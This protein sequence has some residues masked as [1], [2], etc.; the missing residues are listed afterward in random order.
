MI[1]RRLFLVLGI[2]FLPFFYVQAISKSS[3]LLWDESLKN[4]NFQKTKID[5]DLKKQNQ[6]IP[7]SEE[8]HLAHFVHGVLSF[9]RGEMK[10][11]KT[12]LTSSLELREINPYV[13][14]YLGRIAMEQKNFKEAFQAFKRALKLKPQ[15]DLRR[16][17][18]LEL[19][20]VY[21]NQKKLKSARKIFL[22]I[23]KKFQ[24]TETYPDILWDLFNIDEKL[25]Y[26]SKCRW[27]R[28]LFENY[29]D[30]SHS[31]SWTLNP[32]TWKISKRKIRCSVR[33]SSQKKHINQL[34]AL[35]QY[36]RVID[37]IKDSQGQLKKLEYLELL[38]EYEIRAGH[39]QKAYQ[40]LKKH[41]KK[42]K[43]NK[44]FLDIF[45]K[46]ASRSLNHK[47]ALKAFNHRI[48]M[49]KRRG[50]KATLVFRKAFLQYE[51]GNYEKAYITFSKVPKIYRRITYQGDT[52]WY[53]GWTA[54]LQKKYKKALDHFGTL[55]GSFR[56]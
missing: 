47:E 36:S 12:S 53:L 38:A 23:R 29:P 54:Y 56:V 44:K 6:K 25:K 19:A 32:R 17:I 4:L 8:G 22:Q 2:L 52:L 10:E 37:E 46:V 45:I 40:E 13:Y 7:S 15:Y 26:A 50:K 51:L 30:Y 16:K 27:F 1:M 48:Q 3:I 14:Y 35:G 21:L 43:G 49:E 20:K 55:L 31:H 5:V 33:F 9:E 18:K 41:Y 28:Y 24:R 39:P 42:Y 11:A 34:I